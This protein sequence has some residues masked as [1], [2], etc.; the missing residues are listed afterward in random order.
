MGTAQSERR[1]SGDELGGEVE[2]TT[3]ECAKQNFK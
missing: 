2:V 3:N 1:M